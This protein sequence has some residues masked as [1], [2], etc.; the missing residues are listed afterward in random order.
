M[1]SP[2]KRNTPERGQTLVMFV[3]A[4]AVLLGFT[5]MSV[6]VGLLFHDR[7]HLQNSADAAALAGVAEL[8]KK[9]VS[10]MKKAEDWA[11][12]NGVPA[13]EIKTIEVRTTDVPNDTLYVELERD[14][15]WVFGR[16]LGME[17]DAVSASAAAQIQSVNGTSNLMPWAILMGD[18]SCLDAA[19]APISGADCSVKLGSDASTITGWYGALDL[20]GAGG[21]GSEYETNIV[22]GE[23]ATKYCSVGES[24]PTC[25]S[26]VVDA[27]HGNKVGGTGAGIDQRLL[28]EPTCDTNGNGMDDFGEVFVAGDGGIAQYAVACPQS[29]RHIIIPIVSL[30]GI[31]VADVTIEGWALAYLDGYTCTSDDCPSG[32]GHWEVQVTMVDAIYSE[33]ADLIGA[34]NPLSRVSVR[35]LIQ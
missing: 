29:P 6:D 31:P 5:A 25:E 19:N 17:T 32:K 18:S 7:R 2:N 1:N 30:N 12:N 34:Y 11:A 27:L 13:S 22:D 15:D 3:L 35:R 9:P 26:N 23:A 14:F 20:D 24:D 10:A 16:V 8:P 4:L 33:S 28:S 21:G